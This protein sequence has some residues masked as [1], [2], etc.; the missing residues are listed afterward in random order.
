MVL[1]DS[2]ISQIKE[3][4]NDKN[5]KTEPYK[6]SKLAIADKNNVLFLKDTAY[7]LGGSQ[8]K[9]VST[10]AVTSDIKFNNETH[11][12]GKD[13]FEIKEDTPFAKV[14]LL[15]IEDI[16]GQTAFEKIKELEHIRYQFCPEGF[17]T[18][19]S[20]LNMREQIRVSKKAVKKK[21]SFADYGNS[22]ICEYLKNPIVKS[23]ELILVT[24]KDFDYGKLYELSE[25]IKD[26]TSALNHIFDNV[27]FDCKSCNLKEIC[28]E[29]EGMKE[30]HM[31]TANI[32]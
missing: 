32:K 15:E 4:L 6:S 3:L 20:A 26:T 10:I 2:F 1:Y 14:V 11:I 9:C 7:E 22:V 17:M 5:A 12:L 31:K 25:K 29:V 16:D 21:I 27:L 13:I 18:R 8:T 24:E 23:V 30:L 19:A 28:D